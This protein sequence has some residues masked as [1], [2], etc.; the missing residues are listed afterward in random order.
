MQGSQQE[1]EQA[2]AHSHHYAAP[3]CNSGPQQAQDGGQETGPVLGGHRGV[4]DGVL[5][6]GERQGVHRREAERHPDLFKPALPDKPDRKDI[7][8][9]RDWRMMFNPI[10]TEM[11]KT[12]QLR[13]EES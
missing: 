11:K 12:G 13:N 6:Q 7:G 9:V 2:Q 8:E 4:L 3:E 1:G 10:Q 5:C